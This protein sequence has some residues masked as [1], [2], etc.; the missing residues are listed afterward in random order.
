MKWMDEINEDIK[1]SGHDEKEQ[2]RKHSI[3]KIPS[4][5]TDLNKKAYKPRAISFGPYHYGEESLKAMEAQKQRALVH[6]LK[7]CKKPIEFLFQCMDQV[8]DELKDSYMPLDNDWKNDTP[9]FLR[10]MILDG[11][12]ILEILRV[13]DPEISVVDYDENDIVFGKHGKVHV[14]PYVKRDMLMLENQIPMKVLHILT[15]VETGVDE[16]DDYELNTKIIKL[17]NP[18]FIEDTSSNEKIKELGKCM[19]VLDLYR[20]SLILE[21]PSY[22]PPPPKPQK[23]KE[24]CLCLEAGE[25]DHV[26]RSAIELQEAGIRFKKSKTRSLKDFS[27]NRG[28]L[29][30]PALKLDDGTEYMFLNLIAFE[31]IH[32]GAGNE[33]TSFIFLMDT[34]IDS[35]MDVPILSRSGILIN[36]LG[37]DKVVAKLFNS[38][39]KEI[40]VE[41]GGHLDIVRNSM[42]RYCK[43]PW[44]NWHASL[45]HTYFRNPWAIVSLVAAIFLFALTIIQ[46]IY[47]VRQFYQNPNPSPSPTKSPSFPV[48]PRRRP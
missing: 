15:K 25:I 24:N 13:N 47:T 34:I 37:N 10:M 4:Q 26:I 9:K 23:G 2:W 27:F 18:I 17:L 38:M 30:L 11:C 40:P 6:F 32:V 44:K 39:S 45:I 43:K 19:H 3:Y 8:A 31:R 7:R 14:L 5:V 21:E 48:T 41:R 46:T 36:A 20:K 42:N 16:E 35:A 22:P 29:W 33:I 12:F 28:V 1:N